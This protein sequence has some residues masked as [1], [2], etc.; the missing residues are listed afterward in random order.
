VALNDQTR[1]G[2]S[3]IPELEHEF[4]NLDYLLALLAQCP[5][6]EARIAGK[7]LQEA[8]QYL[9]I[10]MYGEY[11]RD[12]EL[13]RGAVARISDLATRENADGIIAELMEVAE[14]I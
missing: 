14:T 7:H 1:E 4:S 8:R 11:L 6:D 10:A 12:L 2:V 13:A 5:L 9:A 3:L